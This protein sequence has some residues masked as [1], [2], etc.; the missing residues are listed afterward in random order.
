MDFGIKESIIAIIT[1]NK[2]VTSSTAPVFY[3]NNEDEQEKTALL[4][5]KITLGMV[6]DLRNG[7]YVV[8]R[9]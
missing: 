6:H 7:V 2:N 1:L 4:I 9:H 8:V 3:V 5:A